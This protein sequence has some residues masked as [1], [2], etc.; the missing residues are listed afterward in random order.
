MIRFLICVFVRLVDF[1]CVWVLGLVE[2]YIYFWGVKKKVIKYI[3]SI[4]FILDNR[5]KY[6]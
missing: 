3:S 2:S 6:V 1:Y 5:L 4:I